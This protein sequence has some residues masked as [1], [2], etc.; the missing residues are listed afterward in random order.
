[1]LRDNAIS[2]REGEMYHGRYR[3]IRC[4][5]AD[6]TGAAYDAVDTM[7]NA[8]HILKVVSPGTILG[9]PVPAQPPRAPL[10]GDNV[11]L[12]SEAGLDQNTKS[13]FQSMGVDDD[14]DANAVTQIF[15][16]HLPENKSFEATLPSANAAP[17]LDNNAVAD[18]PRPPLP[19]PDVPPMRRTV[20]IPLPPPP[21][22][23]RPDAASRPSLPAIP[24]PIAPLPPPLPPPEGLALGANTST[25][26]TT[27]G[28]LPPPLPPPER[29]SL[30]GNTSIGTAPLRPL[31][32]PT[33]PPDRTSRPVLPLP[34][35][36]I[37]PDAPVSPQA[38]L[39]PE[40]K[41]SPPQSRP[42]AFTRKHV[43]A[44]AIAIAIGGGL[45]YFLVN[46]SGPEATTPETAVERPASPP[47]SEPPVTATEQPH[48]DRAGAEPQ[49]PNS[50]LNESERHEQEIA[51]PKTTSPKANRSGTERGVSPNSKRRRETL[52]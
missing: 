25:G 12:L 33:P 49:A 10:V 7:T 45:L 15:D 51:A 19:I 14:F 32:P 9:T 3:I 22:L 29:L 20:S 8:R 47:P 13:V 42:K 6:S 5:E 40:L 31:P 38:S 50:V 41:D 52:Y 24:L 1:M 37:V 35:P 34:P 48:N 27:F 21:P 11:A 44:A 43:V 28:P 30:A 17:A 36:T 4:I 39:I 46:R 2:L 18:S 23:T 26:T 16:G